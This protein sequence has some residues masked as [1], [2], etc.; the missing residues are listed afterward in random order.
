[1]STSTEELEEAL[2]SGTSRTELI[3]HM[4]TRGFSILE[5]IKAT[6]SLFGVS[7]GEAKQLVAN[8]AA[9]TDIASSAAPMHE[10][11]IRA[12][13]DAESQDRNEV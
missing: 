7:L 4:K 11:V 13:E 6:R 10:E 1:M 12:F 8:H 9:W 5:A 3:G 2:R